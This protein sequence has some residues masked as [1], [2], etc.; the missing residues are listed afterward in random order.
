MKSQHWLFVEDTSEIVFT[1]SNHCRFE[2]PHLYRLAQE[3]RQYQDGAWDICGYGDRNK[4]LTLL[5]HQPQSG[6]KIS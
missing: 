2:R 3:R 6:K 4:D 5:L 1:C